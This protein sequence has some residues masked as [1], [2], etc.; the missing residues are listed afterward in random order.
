[1][2]TGKP[3]A[4]VSDVFARNMQALIADAPSISAV[5]RALDINRT[6]FNRYLS[7]EAHPRPEVLAKICAH[8]DRDARI[9]LEPL[10]VIDRDSERA[11]PALGDADPFNRIMTPFDHARMPDGLYQFVMPNMIDPEVVHIDLIR[12]FTLPSGVKGI[13]W[14]IPKFF[15]EITNQPTTWHARK[16][17]GFVYQHVDGVSFLMANPISRQIMMVFTTPGFRGA[18]TVYTG[19]AAMTQTLG[20]MKSQATPLIMTKLPHSF[21]AAIAL[22]RRQNKM[23][24]AALSEAQRHYLDGWT[25]S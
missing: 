7:G 22:R 6:Q 12:L 25:P 3:P 10:E 24:R 13:H 21:R 16:M 20:P 2:G 4:D 8:F 15:A 1:M 19:F 5:C 11:P 23:D 9:L 18:P 17:T 14:S